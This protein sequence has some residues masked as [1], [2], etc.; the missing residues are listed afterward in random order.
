MR[1]QRLEPLIKVTQQRQDDAARAVAERERVVHEQQERLDALR[2][3]AE[4]YAASPANATMSPAL[5]VNRVA[6]RER[7]N[8]AVVQ[9]AGIVSQSQQVT[10]VER[11]RL[12]LASRETL[13]LEK[14]ADSYRAQEAQVQ[15][16]KAQRELDEIGNRGVAA[17]A[18]ALQA[19]GEGA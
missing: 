18:A 12:L 11:A 10:D 4:E 15:Q 17:R 19:E 16:S 6:F 7:L 5:L 8:A 9:Q 13:V 3:Y 14:L 1:S 2:R